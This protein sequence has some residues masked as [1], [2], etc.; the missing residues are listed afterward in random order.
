[1]SSNA[2]S[3][4]L[5]AG[6][7]PYQVE[8]SFGVFSRDAELARSV[9]ETLLAVGYDAAA[10]LIRGG[11]WIALNNE[12]VARAIEMT[13]GV[14]GRRIAEKVLRNLQS[15]CADQVGSNPGAVRI[16]VR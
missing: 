7:R 2:R 16:S 12:A 15:Q 8:E 14:N 9:G 13:A 11:G 4:T 6:G 10:Q 1:M 3:I 5:I